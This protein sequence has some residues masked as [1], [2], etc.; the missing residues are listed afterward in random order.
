[1]TMLIIGMFIGGAIGLITMS[2][3][4]ASARAEAMEDKLKKGE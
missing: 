1:M 4:A 2:L 3:M